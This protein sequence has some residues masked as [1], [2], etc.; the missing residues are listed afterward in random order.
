MS[1]I[2]PMNLSTD[3]SAQKNADNDKNTLPKSY[4]VF[5]YPFKFRLPDGSKDIEEYISDNKWEK[6][7]DLKKNVLDEN[8]FPPK[9][10]EY[11]GAQLDGEKSG[12]SRENTTDIDTDSSAAK[13]IDIRR[14]QY[15]VYRYFLPKALD[16]IFNTQNNSDSFITYQRREISGAKYIIT[17]TDDPQEAKTKNYELN[18]NEIRL[19]IYKKLNIGL[20][21]F[22]LSNHAYSVA[23]IKMIN[24]YGRRLFA[25][26]YTVAE[27]ENGSAGEQ[28][29]ECRESSFEL[30][31]SQTAKRIE[32]RFDDQSD[33]V[34]LADLMDTVG[35]RSGSQR[36][37]IEEPILGLSRFIFDSD[38]NMINMVL[39]DRMFTCCLIR[40]GILSRQIENHASPDGKEYFRQENGDKLRFDFN[41]KLYDLYDMLYTILYVDEDSS[42]C[43]DRS[44]QRQKLSEYTD[45]RWTGYGTIHGVTEYSMICITGEQDYLKSTVIEPFL[46]EYVELARLG[47]AQAAAMHE[48]EDQIA[49]INKTIDSNEKMTEDAIDKINRA[50]KRYALFENDMYIPEVTF[51]EQG[52]EMYDLVKK[53]FR[54]NML[55]EY[56]H[57]ELEQLHALAS[58]ET[59]RTDRESDDRISNAINI[60]TILGTGLALIGIFQDSLGISE[61]FGNQKLNWCYRLFIFAV[62]TSGA[63][64]IYFGYLCM[65]SNSRKKKTVFQKIKEV[66]RRFVTCTKPKSTKVFSILLAVFLILLALG[67]ILSFAAIIYKIGE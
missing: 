1:E 63:F 38:R 42:S 55:N 39:D 41:G 43:Q 50:W 18:I 5:I 54:L 35:R 57:S 56:L 59:D 48:Q 22:S 24:Q 8:V 58:L 44:M 6:F 62:Y 60:V 51:Q 17:R 11:N 2:A 3:T 16:N 4:H 21:S 30:M 13:A 33:P 23:D 66:F 26:Y 67:I 32:I 15:S 47:L 19:T 45:T 36:G 7:P 46:N 27:H 12:A 28:I 29:S 34:V 61:A 10:Q 37:Q 49:Q 52:R 25:P 14:Q 53:S 65:K 9:E 31:C 40:D 20:I 64:V